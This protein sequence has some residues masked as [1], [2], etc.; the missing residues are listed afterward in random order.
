M[1]GTD[2]WGKHSKTFNYCAV[3][4]SDRYPDAQIPLRMFCFFV[5]ASLLYGRGIAPLSAVLRGQ[6]AVISED[7]DLVTATCACVNC[8]S[9]RSPI[10]QTLT[11]DLAT[12]HSD[13]PFAGEAVLLHHQTVMK[14]QRRSL[15]HESYRWQSSSE[16]HQVPSHLLFSLSLPLLA[17]CY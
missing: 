8:H 15:P 2:R 10:T 9:T 16:Q 13:T 17:L 14:R 5:I 11:P 3:C 6:K 12:F 1:R 7:F 4:F